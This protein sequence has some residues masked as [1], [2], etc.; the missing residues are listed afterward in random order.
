MAKRSAKELFEQYHTA[1]VF[2]LPVKDSDF[3]DELHKH[4]L[5]PGDLKTKLE[6][7]IER[8]ERS[9]YFLDSII[10]PGLAVGKNRHFVSLL[11]VMKNSKY[12]NVQDLARKIE[13]DLAAD[14]KCKIIVL[15]LQLFS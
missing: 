11:T 5:L 9:S 15:F 1:L 10:K 13:E 2:V 12:E 3:M 6:S 14:T 4:D 7:L 8:N